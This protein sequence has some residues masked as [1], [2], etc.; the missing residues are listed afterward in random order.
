M[1]HIKALLVIIVLVFAFVVS[2]QNYENLKTPLVFSIDII[3]YKYESPRM[4]LAS[5]TVIA[6]LAGLIFMGF[7][8]MA[9]RFR[10]KRQIRSLRD[11]VR[12]RDKEFGSIRNLSAPVESVYQEKA[13]DME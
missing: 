13:D 3:F 6:F 10:M 12:R 7:F 9:E 2:V 8:G 4:S 1:K 5:V 11:E